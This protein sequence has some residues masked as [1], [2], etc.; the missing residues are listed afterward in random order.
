MV[1]RGGGGPPV[2]HNS[3]GAVKYVEVCRGVS[4]LQTKHV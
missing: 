3:L 4:E 1:E 2:H